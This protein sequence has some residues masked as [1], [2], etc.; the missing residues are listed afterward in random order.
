M[1]RKLLPL[2]KN[3]FLS[4]VQ[5]EQS[6]ERFFIFFDE[7]SN[8]WL[9]IP[10]A[11]ISESELNLLKAL[12]PFSKFPIVNH[13]PE[14]KVWHDFL[15]SDGQPPV[16]QSNS[17]FRCLQFH[18]QD[19]SM[20]DQEEIESAFKGFFSEDIFIVWE[21]ENSGI[22][23]EEMKQISL[24]EKEII[25]MSETVENDFYVKIYFYIGKEYSFS[26][27]LRYHFQRE[28]E[29]FAFGK[30]H[31]NST[32]IFTFERVFPAYT[33][34]HLPNELS[35]KLFHELE[36]VFQDDPEMFTTIKT[37]LENNL[38][39]SV[40]AKKL[41]IHRNT[42]QYRIDKFTE[43]TGIGL[44]DFYGAFTVFLACLLFDQKG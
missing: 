37:F 15:L 42:L 39:A 24:S 23:I 36:D 7:D 40:T 9:G 31:I 4:T 34:Y 21:N 13:T 8:E 14:T 35:E 41:Y 16:Y 25:A 5:P 22:V 10:K 11:E 18:L 20:E 2:F 27:Q 3:S 12:F 38:N 32:N 19:R 43:K 17:N 29:Y 26:E 33:A 30:D 6:S 1:L 28:R 44:K